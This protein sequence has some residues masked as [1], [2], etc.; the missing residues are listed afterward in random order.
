MNATYT[1]P[2]VV[3]LGLSF[4]WALKPQEEPLLIIGSTGGPNIFSFFAGD[5]Y[6]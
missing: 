1:G 6:F 2:N 5:K 4:I 3:R